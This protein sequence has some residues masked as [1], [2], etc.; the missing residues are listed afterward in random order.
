[1]LSTDWRLFLTRRRDGR[2]MKQ[3]KNPTAG[4]ARGHQCSNGTQ[5]T[6][7]FPMAPNPQKDV[8]QEIE[9]VAAGFEQPK[10]LRRALGIKY[11][12]HSLVG[13]LVLKPRDRGPKVVD[14]MIILAHD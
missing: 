13:R 8:V 11:G 7:A 4:V 2:P 1:M 5:F 12:L 10:S 3:L 9:A 14:Q 6:A